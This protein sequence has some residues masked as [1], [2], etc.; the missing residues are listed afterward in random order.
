MIE[1]GERLCRKCRTFRPAPG[2]RWCRSCKNASKRGARARRNGTTLPPA[3][4]ATENAAPVPSVSDVPIENAVPMHEASA[5]TNHT[6]Q[7][8]RARR[9]LAR[10]RADYEASRA[11]D[12]RRSAVP[13]NTVLAPLAQWVKDAERTCQ[14]LG[15]DLR[16]NRP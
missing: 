2:Q 10:A 9:A 3:W 15:V 11:Q 12:W 14:R 5:L 8:E 4:T 16:E 7:M 13:P 6:H 1:D